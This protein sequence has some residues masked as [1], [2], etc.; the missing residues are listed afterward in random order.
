MRKSSLQRHS[1]AN[2]H[3]APTLWSVNL[4]SPDSFRQQLLVQLAA[5][6]AGDQHPRR[7]QSLATTLGT[8]AHILLPGIEV[9]LNYETIPLLVSAAGAELNQV[10]T[11][12]IENAIDAMLG[13]GE[14]RLRT[15]REDN[16]VVVEI[17]DSGSGIPAEIK[18]H[19]F[20]PSLRRRV[21][22]K[23]RASE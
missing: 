15:F 12:L 13:H 16:Y 14:L 7:N 6:A 1:S 22:A 9:K 10:W 5:L 23:E 19:I 11:N 17:G 2:A 21:S 4:A 8:L 18:P 20:G 3:R